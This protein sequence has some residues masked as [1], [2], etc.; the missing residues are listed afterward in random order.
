MYEV[1]FKPSYGGKPVR[2]IKNDWHEATALCY[3]LA[4]RGGLSEVT[5]ENGKVRLSVFHSL[6]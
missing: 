6:D 3:D 1:T 2:S 4:D 5:D